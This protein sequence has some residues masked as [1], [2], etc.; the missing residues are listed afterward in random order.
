MKDD[1]SRGPDGFGPAFLKKFWHLTSPLLLAIANEF[2]NGSA[3]LSRINQS[4]IVLL[5][6]SV[7]VTKPEHFRP[8]SL[9]NCPLKIICKALTN[10]LQPLIPCL[11]HPNQ[12][13]FI[14]GRSISENFV[15]AAD[16]VQTCLKRN[17]PS[18]SLKLD[19]R[20]AF[21]SIEWDALDLILL[22]KNFP[23][24]W[25]L[26]IKHIL[27]SSQTAVLLNGTPG[28]W[29]RCKKGLR[30]GDP[31]SP[32]LFILVADVLQQLLNEASEFWNIRS[33]LL[34]LVPS[35]NMPM[36]CLS[37]SSRLTCSNCSV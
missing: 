6:K 35:C 8:I 33:L 9:Q 21:D 17:I 26:W 27:Q 16:L 11:V 15:Y 14:R 25:C 4:Y 3:D 18:I 20:K 31:L 7:G 12:T 30:Q 10:R 19:F 24:I 29:I 37:S 5:P 34:P 28:K 2:C 32:Y 36:T 23:S 13:G 1:S 22:A